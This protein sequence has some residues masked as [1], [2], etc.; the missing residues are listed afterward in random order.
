VTLYAG[1][2]IDLLSNYEHLKESLAKELFEMVKKEVNLSN[3]T[4]LGNE[5]IPLSLFA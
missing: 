1:F 2:L 3:P 5:T 4:I